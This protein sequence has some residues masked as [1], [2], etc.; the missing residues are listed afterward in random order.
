MA[1]PA[2]VLVFN[3]QPVDLTVLWDVSRGMGVDVRVAGSETEFARE[4]ITRRP[5]AAVLGLS[6]ETLSGLNVIN[7]IR[8]AHEDLPVIVIAEEDSLELERRARETGLFYYLVGPVSRGEM[9]AVLKSLLRQ[10]KK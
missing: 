6:R 2:E 9:R 4:A 1:T 7:V 8:A 3:C 10:L 5:S